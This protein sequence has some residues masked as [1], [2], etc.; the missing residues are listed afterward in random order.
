[1]MHAKADLFA[2]KACA[3]QILATDD[4]AEQKRLGSLV[5]NFDQARWDMWKLDIVYEGNRARFEQNPGA[6]RQLKATEE[7][8]LVE[9]N[10]R[11]WIWGI[12]RSMD[13]P[14]VSD[15][16]QWRGTNFL[17]R[18]LTLIKRELS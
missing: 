15:P 17:G 3:A 4:P 11:D 12:G 7:A 18:I 14:L 5:R 6:A 10:P 8:M 9:A 16:A 13:D 1:M 2:D